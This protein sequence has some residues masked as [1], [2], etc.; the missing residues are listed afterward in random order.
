MKSVSSSIK[1]WTFIKHA[2][3][4]SITRETY[5]SI[6]TNCS[7]MADKCIACNKIVSTRQQAI[8]C[9]GCL[10]WNHRTCNTGKCNLLQFFVNSLR[11][12]TLNLLTCNTGKC[13]LLQFFVNSLHCSLPH[14][15]IISQAFLNKSIEKLSTPA[16][17]YS[18][19]VSPVR[20]QLRRV[21][22]SHQSRQPPF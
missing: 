12:L 21:L 20:C 22:E 5:S 15:S 11:Y 7:R 2:T 13:N 14:S 9:D 19:C 1:A 18:G 8:Q 10:K 6:F 16:R 3:R 4:S 17:E